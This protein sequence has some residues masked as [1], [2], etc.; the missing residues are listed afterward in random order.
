MRL[1]ND[2]EILGCYPTGWL[3]EEI[4]ETDRAIAKAQHQLDIK[5]FEK[6]VRSKTKFG[7]NEQSATYNRALHNVLESLKQLMEE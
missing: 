1:L 7:G 2:E 6:L 4:D 3:L 5:D